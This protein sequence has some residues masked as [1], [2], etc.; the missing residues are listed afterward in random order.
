MSIKP[1]FREYSMQF[2]RAM[3]WGWLI[4]PVAVVSGLMVSL[5][6]WLLDKSTFTFQSNHWLIYLMP[7][8]GILI[9]WLYKHGKDSGKGNN[10]IIAAIQ[11]PSKQVTA[12]MSPLI[13]FTTV[14]THLVGGS[15]GREG[16]AVQMGGSIAGI[17]FRFFKLE[18]KPQLVLLRCGAAAGFGAVFGTPL[19]GA[20]FAI[21]FSRIGILYWRSILPCLFS[22][23]IADQTVRFTGIEHSSYRIDYS[24]AEFSFIP[25]QPILFIQ[26]LM[27]GIAFGLTAR[28]FVWIAEAVK[29]TSI[30]LITNPYLIPVVASIFIWSITYVLGTYDYLGLG[31]E[32]AN[33][34]GISILSS[35]SNYYINPLGWWW[36]L[37][38]TA[39]TLSM[40]FKGGE[41]TPLFFIGATLGH[42][43]AIY[44][45]A[46][47][48]L[49]AGLGLIAVFAGAANTPLA[50][51]VMGLELFG[52]EHVVYMITVCFAAFIFSGKQGIYAAQEY[53]L[54]D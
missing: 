29:S 31:V 16:T 53:G 30:K 44:A 42:T 40:G 10:L 22:A 2:Y 19:A 23:V 51:V 17:P 20:V 13:L 15:A 52:T 1:Q 50:C 12:R 11:D 7:L 21:E 35:F 28:L 4:V 8:A 48:D 25:V 9:T 33:Q 54:R 6:L 39:I 46:P 47:V 49:F 34:G 5:F 18:K 14:L 27:A 3:K 41:V 45:G 37:L 36:K 32:S 43:L 24:F 26:V 38:L